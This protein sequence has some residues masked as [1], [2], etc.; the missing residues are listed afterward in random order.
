[1]NSC[2]VTVE[3]Q[4]PDTHLKRMRR[5]TRPIFHPVSKSFD[6]SPGRTNVFFYQAENEG[7]RYEKLKNI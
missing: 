2:E 5:T 1:M 7:K 4:S 6:V 3:L